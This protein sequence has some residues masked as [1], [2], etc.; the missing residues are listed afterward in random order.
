MNQ[1][2]YQTTI[3]SYLRIW[4]KYWLDVVSAWNNNGKLFGILK[5]LPQTMHSLNAFAELFPSRA[6]SRVLQ[7]HLTTT[8]AIWLAAQGNLEQF[9]KGE[10]FRDYS[11]AAQ[12]RASILS[13]DRAHFAQAL[14]QF[15]AIEALKIYTGVIKYIS[16]PSARVGSDTTVV[17]QS[18]AAQ[19]LDYGGDGTPVLFIPSLVNKSYILDLIPEHSLISFVKQNGLHPY[20]IDWGE[21]T[22]QNYSLS[23]YF[24]QVLLPCIQH[25]S[26]THGK[27][28]LVGY[29][30]GGN[31]AL[32]A[33]LSSDFVGNIAL[34]ATPWDF[35]EM[36]LQEAIIKQPL[37]FDTYP[38]VPG[39]LLQSF[40]INQDPDKLVHKFAK[41][42]AKAYDNEELFVAI[43][44]WVNDPVDLS[45]K[46][47]KECFNQW[48]RENQT[49]KGSW[50]L[51][52]KPVVLNSIKNK[53]LIVTGARDS[54]VPYQSSQPLSKQLPNSKDI[55]GNFGHTGLVTSIK[56]KQSLWEDMTDW[57]RDA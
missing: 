5:S 21:S 26:S 8:Y 30:M 11:D 18:G 23:D 29:C 56:A 33:A 49:M 40:F 7:T 2:T 41:F 36:P 10:Y 53:A 42:Q 50:Q 27:V 9:L 44:D 54:L 52:K 37:G 34:I 46:V 15:I 45:T 51:D 25:L 47:A 43:E 32:A 39:E 17:W 4:R 57:I 20:L 35:S 6:R 3:D 1:I 19:L 48:F 28:T 13:I 16:Y 31:L 22:E 12:V 14:S 38:T 55:R 24:Q